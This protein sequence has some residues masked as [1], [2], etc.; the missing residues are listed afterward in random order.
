M[1]GEMAQTARRTA[2]LGRTAFTS[3]LLA[4]L[5][6][7]IYAALQK[8]PI[9]RRAHREYNPDDILLP[10]GYR[11]E[12]V[13]GG[14]N[15]P[16]HC[17]FGPDGACYVTEAGHKIDAAPRVLRIDVTTGEMESY[18]AI[19]EDNWLK[20]GAFTGTCWVG[21][22]MLLTG[23]DRIW[24]VGRDRVMKELVSGLPG[25]G[26]H[27]TNYPVVG[28]DGRV[29][30]GQGSATNA[31]IVGPDNFAYEWLGRFP[32]VC[33]VPGA[34]V[35][36][37]GRNFEARDVVRKTYETVETGVYSPFGTPTAH[38]QLIKGSTRCTGAVLS[39]KPDGR[40]LRVEAWGL[41]NPY[42]IA[43]HPDG[44][45]FVTE[46]GIDERGARWIVGDFD[47]LYEIQR[48]G[49]YGW[50]DFASG[51][52]LDSEAWGTRGEGRQPVLEDPPDPNPPQPVAKLQPHC[53]ANGLDF[54]RDATFGF[55]GQAFVA[56]FGDLFPVTTSRVRPAGFK[57]V[58]V[59]VETGEVFD[60]AVNRIAG[61]ESKLPHRG[62]ERPSHCQFGPDGALYIV[63]WGE[64]EIA[65]EKGGVRM[66]V[67]GGALW[68]ISRTG[69]ARGEVPPKPL[70]VYANILPA[71]IVLAVA[72]AA[73]GA[74]VAWR[75]RGR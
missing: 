37:S 62:M 10:E 39:C 65:P 4:Y 7:P 69:A 51:I 63:D 6:A 9:T 2:L 53:G 68:R 47:D 48:G 1:P 5:Y 54:C 30:W 26:D 13:T 15:A 43:V 73:V 22:T 12:L 35:T 55:E 23:S 41:R 66:A 21:E 29:Y 11:A 24:A 34:D 60:F 74:A 57:V 45:I 36:V 8:L 52:R 19:P 16:V 17:S 27:Q 50:P 58:R 28:T 56:L 46:H 18:L 25:L 59:D 40:D 44:R 42:G 71:A 64:I 3:K 75:R 61:P 33:D 38:G 49:W 20:S 31:G 72:G 14:L 70:E 67:G 32:E